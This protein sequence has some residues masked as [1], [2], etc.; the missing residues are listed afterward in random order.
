MAILSSDPYQAAW[1]VIGMI[2]VSLLLLGALGLLFIKFIYPYLPANMLEVIKEFFTD[3]IQY[4]P[5]AVFSFG[6]LH[7]IIFQSYTALIPNAFAI[8]GLIINRV[9]RSFSLSP[10]EAAFFSR[11]AAWQAASAAFNFS[12]GPD[13][14]PEPMIAA[15]FGDKSFCYISGMPFFDNSILPPSIILVTTIIW[16]Y[17][18]LQWLSGGGISTIVPSVTLAILLIGHTTLVLQNCADDG[19]SITKVLLA[20]IAGISLGSASMAAVKYGLNKGGSSIGPTGLLGAPK[21]NDGTPGVGTCSAPNDQDQ[22]V[23]EAYKNGELI[24]ETVVE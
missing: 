9:F 8:L 18:M 23:C 2:L 5:T 24:T 13:P 19:W 4:S 1:Q 16:H 21:G 22:F 17:L 10:R 11:S 20:V 15:P 3:L 7:S 12:G 14:G 6:F